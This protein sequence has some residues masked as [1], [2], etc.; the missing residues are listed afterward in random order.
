M[1]L[2]KEDIE[3]LGWIEDKVV[4]G[5]K[6]Y[7]DNYVMVYYYEGNLLSMIVRDLSKNKEYTTFMNEPSVR[8][9]KVT[10]KGELELLMKMFRIDEV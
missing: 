9:L 6:Y 4:P 10:S 3:S 7:N 2:T 8:N 1:G 5:I